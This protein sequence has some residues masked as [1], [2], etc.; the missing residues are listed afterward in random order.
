MGKLFRN[1][2]GI[3]L[4]Y[5]FFCILMPIAA[6]GGT[7]R[8]L[9]LGGSGGSHQPREMADLL[10]KGLNG[11]G[12]EIDYT[13]DV[14]RLKPEEFAKHDVILIYKDNGDLPADAEKALFEAV[15]NGK[16][17]V[18]VHCAS[19][20]FR[21]SP[22]YGALVGGRFA[23][24]ADAVFRARIIDAQHPAMRGVKS[25]ESWDETYVHNELAD[26]IRVLMTRESDGGYEPYTWVR[27]QGK[28]RVYYTALGHNEKTWSRPEFHQLIEQAIR[29]AAGQLNDEFPD[30][31]LP[32]NY[33]AADPPAPL[34]ANDSMKRMHFPE[35]FHA[36][37][38][39]SEPD[40]VR[41]LAMTFDERGRAW[42]IESTD[43]PNDVKKDGIGNDRIKICE[44]TDG[45]GRADKYIVFAEGLNI[46]T[47]LLCFSGGVIV[48]HPPDILFLKD[49]DG[50]GKADERKV[51][52]TGFGRSDTHAV[53]GNLRYGL[54]NWISA[55]IGYS[56]AKMMMDGRELKFGAGIFRFKPDGLALEFLTPTESN[57]WGLGFS[58]EG[59]I[60]ASKANDQHHV[61]LAIPNRFYESVRGW[62]GIGNA[63]IED[64]KKFHP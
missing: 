40:I 3:D 59:N 9:V 61:Q 14:A 32:E 34:A 25:F 12:I 37:L 29:W 38:F 64:H 56:G 27:Q 4:C 62:H 50:D 5:G 22:R 41:P 58:E 19:H 39:A 51:L 55:T 45:D 21:N 44:D 1:Q 35:G 47:S 26:D 2:H 7:T 24:H 49:T 10:I 60:F 17:L 15:E 43:Y 53:L 20:A 6:M 11:R 52:Y 63:G 57:T 30:A 8:V 28:G 31:P 36:E 48:A 42:I 18:A 46:P 16:G 33:L 54:D 23:T 13:E